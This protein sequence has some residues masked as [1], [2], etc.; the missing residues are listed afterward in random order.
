MF[1]KATNGAVQQLGYSFVKED[2]SRVVAGIVGGTDV[3][4]V[5]PTGYRNSLCYMVSSQFNLSTHKKRR[6]N[7]KI[8]EIFKLEHISS[9]PINLPPISCATDFTD[10]GEW[11]V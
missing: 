11:K 9:Q 1:R 7:A 5:L 6:Q 3:F 2:Q 4:A 8:I 10:V